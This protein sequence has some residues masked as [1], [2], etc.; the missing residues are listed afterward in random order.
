M[1]LTGE[2]ERQLDVDGWT[3]IDV[4]GPDEC[5]LLAR[6]LGGIKTRVRGLGAGEPLL[7]HT[8][9]SMESP[10]LADYLADERI[11]APMMALL[12]P[13]VRVFWEQVITRQPGASGT[14]PWHQ[15]AG[16]SSTF[17]DEMFGIWLALT[18]ADSSNGGLHM[19]SGSHE[20]GLLRHQKVPPALRAVHPE[21]MPSESESV[22]ISLQ[23]G[24]AIVF[25]PYTVHASF[26]NT[27]NAARMGWIVHYAAARAIHGATGKSLDNRPWV[28]RDGQV[29]GEYQFDEQW[30][31]QQPVANGWVDL[32]E[33]GTVLPRSG[34]NV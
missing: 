26:A 25:T 31:W 17:G 23:K 2:Q 28:A 8:M 21:D 27:T 13:D 14:L 12:G 15:D 1:N 6:Y 20:D 29:L 33:D 19:I 32:D 3:I 30:T 10:L 24:Q 7:I 22:S 34:Q 5:D 9:A 16:Y 11:V 18:D 4:L